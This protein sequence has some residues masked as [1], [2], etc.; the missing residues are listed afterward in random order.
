MNVNRLGIVK[1]K[2]KFVLC[3]RSLSEGDNSVFSEGATTPMDPQISKEDYKQEHDASGNESEEVDDI[4]LI[5]TTD[6]SKDMSNLQVT[7]AF[8]FFFFKSRHM[9]QIGCLPMHKKV[10]CHH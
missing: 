10:K 8:F 3:F 6:E 1:Q 4:E 5:F 9:P 2:Y 7:F